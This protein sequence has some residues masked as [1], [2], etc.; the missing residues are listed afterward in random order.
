M[1]RLINQSGLIILAALLVSCV[2]SWNPLYTDKDLIFDPALVGNWKD[3]DDKET[4]AFEKAGE[5]SYKLTHT[6]EEKHVGKFEA[7]LLKI[8]SRTFLDLYLTEASE[9]D[10]ECNSL[11][12]A[13]L[14]PAH[15]FLRVDEL[16]G[17]F[18]MAAPNPEWLQKHLEANPGAIAYRRIGDG[19]FIFTAGSKELQAFVTK[20]ADG[21]ALFGEPFTLKRQ[22]GT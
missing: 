21:E 1:K 19:Q 9:K 5:K 17:S 10:L 20:H 14:V 6:D 18:K 11:A 12:K 3:K 2:P 4:W 7:H 15:L 8:G 13:M 16:G 22:S